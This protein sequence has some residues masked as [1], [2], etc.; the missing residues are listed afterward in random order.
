MNFNFNGSAAC[1]DRNMRVCDAPASMRWAQLSSWRTKPQRNSGCSTAAS[2]A[3]AGAPAGVNTVS[4]TALPAMMGHHPGR[5]N[6]EWWGRTDEHLCSRDYPNPN[7]SQEGLRT[8]ITS[9]WWQTIL[10]GLVGVHTIKLRHSGV[11]ERTD[12]QSFL[13][14]TSH[15]CVS[16]ASLTDH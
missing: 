10:S 15:L 13:S 11:T 1:S 6:K 8:S 5:Q 4:S 3:A 16:V 2:G 9:L 14:C 7:P 12:Q